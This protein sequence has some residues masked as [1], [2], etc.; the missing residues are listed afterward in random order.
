MVFTTNGRWLLEKET[1]MTLWDR[2]SGLGPDDAAPACQARV[3]RALD[4]AWA[5]GALAGGGMAARPV[6]GE[7]AWPSLIAQRRAAQNFPGVICVCRFG[8]HS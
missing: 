8:D 2:L 6:G 4:G 5:I 7:S 3:E 1:Q